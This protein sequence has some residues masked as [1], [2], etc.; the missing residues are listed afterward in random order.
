MHKV[1]TGDFNKALRTSRE[2]EAFYEE[3]ALFGKGGLFRV[4][5]GAFAE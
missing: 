3:G 4:R 5:E 1:E 2:K